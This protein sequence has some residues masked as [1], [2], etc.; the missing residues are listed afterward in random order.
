MG[1]VVGTWQQLRD[2][3]T[4]IVLPLSR[5]KVEYPSLFLLLDLLDW[6]RIHLP[7]VFDAITDPNVT[8]PSGS[9]AQDLLSSPGR[10]QHR[11]HE[12]DRHRHA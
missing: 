5:P 3:Q 11:H 8:L 2:S 7:D 10:G 4:T 1:R 9:A 12:S 6:L